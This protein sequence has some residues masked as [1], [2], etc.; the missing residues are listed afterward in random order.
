[1][2]LARLAILALLGLGLMHPSSTAAQATPARWQPAPDT[3]RQIQINGNPDTSIV[4]DA[5][6]VD[7]CETSATKIRALQARGTKVICSFSAGSYEEWRPDRKR[8]PRAALGRA[9]DGWEGER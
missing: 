5:Y 2:T 8:F 9:S 3:S 4:A 1:M 6:N 7:L